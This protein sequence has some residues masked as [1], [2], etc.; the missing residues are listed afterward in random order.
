MPLR[1]TVRRTIAGLDVRIDRRSADGATGRRPPLLLCSGLGAGTDMFDPLLS[2]LDP[3]VDV[4]LFDSPG[5][6]DSSAS[7]LPLGFPV[8]ARA[9]FAVL[10]ELAYPQV[11]VLGYSWGGALAQQFA[12]QHSRRCRR[13]VLISTSTGVISVPGDVRVLASMMVPPGL[14]VPGHA[15]LLKKLFARTDPA[16]LHELRTMLRTSRVA[17]TGTGYLH[18]LAA[19]GMWTSLPFLPF[20]SQPVLVLSGMDDPIVPVAN[21][22]LMSSLIPRAQ[23]VT[24][25]GGHGQIITG[26]GLIAPH[27]TGFL[28][29]QADAD[30]D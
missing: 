23:L 26:A 19:L 24:F 22:R 3:D 9:L 28:T 16:Q 25:P 10:D 14:P 29:D 7:P 15:A 1:T 30:A 8:L 17:T 27:I 20:I 2:A 6:A 4:I 11:D 12:L 5:I 18:Q 13:L 21:A